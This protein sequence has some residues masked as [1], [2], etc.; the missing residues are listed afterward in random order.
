MLTMSTVRSRGH[1][2]SLTPKIQRIGPSDIN[3]ISDGDVRLLPCTEHAVAQRTDQ[4][5]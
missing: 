3:A 5:S 4:P 1:L 2:G